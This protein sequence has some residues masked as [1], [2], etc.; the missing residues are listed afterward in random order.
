M[1]PTKGKTSMTAHA[2]SRLSAQSKTKDTDLSPSEG[3]PGRERAAF[4]QLS[5]AA[6]TLGEMR[7]LGLRYWLFWHTSAVHVLNRQLEMLTAGAT[8]ADVSLAQPKRGSRT[9]AA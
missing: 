2:E 6:T 9:T 5:L 1:Q 8:E 7:R 4:I 3:K